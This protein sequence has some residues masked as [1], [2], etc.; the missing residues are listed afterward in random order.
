MAKKEKIYLK[1][2]DLYIEIVISKAQDELTPRAQQMLLLLAN[3]AIN[4][5]R[6]ANPKDRE[7]CLSFAVLDLLKYWRGFNPKYKNAFAYF[8]EISKRGFAKGWNKI[9]PKKY[10]GTM[11]ID[12]FGR[13]GGGD[14][15]SGIYSI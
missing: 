3:R 13:Q 4:K 5:L 1:N 10:H 7:D 14:T 15:D 6:Y 9:Y 11:S 8:T 2:K 12:G